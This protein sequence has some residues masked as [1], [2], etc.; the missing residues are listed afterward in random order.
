MQIWPDSIMDQLPAHILR[1]IEEEE[2]EAR[3]QAASAATADAAG[4]ATTAVP[5]AEAARPVVVDPLE[6]ER[7]EREAAR[8]FARRVREAR[9]AARARAL[10][11]YP[12]HAPSPVAI[13]AAG[14]RPYACASP[15]GS[16]PHLPPPPLSPPSARGLAEASG[17]APHNA[18]QSG[19][20]QVPHHTP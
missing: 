17:T 2:A 10:A 20:G 1:Q 5:A 14:C 7:A 4:G 3:K 13:P 8:A 16:L 18:A 12:L 6:R 19:S 9:D 11:R 15:P